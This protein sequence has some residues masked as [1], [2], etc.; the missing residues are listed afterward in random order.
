MIIS[1]ICFKWIRLQNRRIPWF[2]YQKTEDGSWHSKYEQ[3]YIKKKTFG[4]TVSHQENS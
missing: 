4:R 1:S 3:F 2:G